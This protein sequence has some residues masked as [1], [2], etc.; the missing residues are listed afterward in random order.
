MSA[1]VSLV[2]AALWFVPG[3]KKEA[4]PP[5]AAPAA[6]SRPTATGELV[7]VIAEKLEAPGY[8]YL[9]LTRAPEADVWVAVPTATLEVGTKVTALNPMPM[10]NFESKTLGRTFP[11][12]MFASGAQ[13]V[14]AAGAPT[15]APSPRPAAPVAP[16]A[17]GE[18]KVDKATGADARTVAEIYG[19]RAA[20]KGKPVSV[21]AK[22]VKVTTG[23]LD[24]N[25]LHLRD[26]SGSEATEDF[27]LIVT[28]AETVQLDD[29]VTVQ[30]ALTVDKDLGSGYAYKVLIEDAKI[31]R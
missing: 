23:V 12:V 27:D 28:T 5:P 29:V 2:I 9:R 20:L 8:T 4:A 11:L 7:G 10:E 18:L 13:P 24:R 19:Q 15:A 26:G 31:V 22:V 21:R 6:P 25:W 16:V 3:C 1:R 14:G 30:G 17:L